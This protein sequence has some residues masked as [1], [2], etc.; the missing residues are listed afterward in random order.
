MLTPTAHVR[1]AS[2]ASTLETVIRSLVVSFPIDLPEVAMMCRPDVSI[3][4]LWLSE[5]AEIRIEIKYGVISRSGF[6][7]AA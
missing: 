4:S 1:A 7:W 2:G 3:M 6:S 5:L